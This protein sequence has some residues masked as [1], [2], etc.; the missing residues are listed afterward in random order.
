[1]T[2][3]V[4]AREPEPR[5]EARP[6]VALAA[7]PRWAVIGIFLMLLIGGMAYARSFLMPVVMAF[8]L[9]LVFSPIRRSLG[10]VG[11]PAGAA[12]FLIV[13]LLLVGIVA[14]V[15]ALA[16]PV[17]GWIERAPLIGLQLDW[18]LRELRGATESVRDVA[19]QMER[20]TSGA[21]D[22]AVQRVVVE[23]GGNVLMMAATVPAVLAQV[24]F[25]LVLLFFLLASGDL[26]YQKIVYAMPTF[27]D[28]RRAVLIARDIERKLSHYLLTIT[29]INV[30][31]GV[32]VGLALWWLGMP[33]PL[34]FGVMACLLNYV[35]FLGAVIGVVI[36]TIVAI[37]TFPTLPPA[38][39]VGAVYFLLTAVEGQIITP[40][41]VG[42]RL[43]LNA[44]VVFLSV[45]LFAWLWSVIGM[46]VATPLLV[47]VRTF[48][49]HVPG[50][51]PFGRFLSD[52][53][54]GPD[55]EPGP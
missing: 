13:G 10:R 6:P 9:A 46:L 51:Q 18:K 34:L 15:G 14:G 39:A 26:F 1:V 55:G 21:D 11:V 36:A 5:P 53:E 45:T 44:V 38:F 2:E 25:T 48:C 50:L 17:S 37:L 47:L 27:P 40:W 22:P 32:A 41:L 35:P 43:Q 42:R 20:L 33:N 52:R 24:A 12:A 31:L 16:Q 23:D 4:A 8:L 3:P 30:G 19:E 28:K 54:G 29:L 7:A 49:E